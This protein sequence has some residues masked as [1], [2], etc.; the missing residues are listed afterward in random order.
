MRL[1]F[2]TTS[3][4]ELYIEMCNK[5]ERLQ[6]GWVPKL[7]DYC[8]DMG[9]YWHIDNIDKLKYV[10][11][12]K[13]NDTWL[14]TEE[15]LQEVIMSL[16]TVKRPVDL[17]YYFTKWVEYR[18]LNWTIHSENWIAWYNADYRNFTIKQLWLC[19][20]MESYFNLEW[21]NGEWQGVLRYY[22]PRY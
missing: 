15:Q 14:P 3:A 10:T 5:A 1:N 18:F 16:S 19:F 11:H 22:Q 7:G 2:V 21:R 13:E 12:C 8:I 20:Y 9:D 6:R 17:L 4:E